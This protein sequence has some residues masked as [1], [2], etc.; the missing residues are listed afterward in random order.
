MFRLESDDRA[1][2]VET[3]DTEIS[4]GLV[5]REVSIDRRRCVHTVGFR[6]DLNVAYSTV[7]MIEMADILD[8]RI[9]GSG[10]M[11][12]AMGTSLSVIRDSVDA[13]A[14]LEVTVASG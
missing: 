11:S 2:T 5:A 3:L 12:G 10:A 9:V 4:S 8:V 7:F 13:A 6:E 1:V 14:V